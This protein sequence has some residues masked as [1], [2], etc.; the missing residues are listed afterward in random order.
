MPKI[1]EGMGSYTI[2]KPRAELQR[3]KLEAVRRGIT[4]AEFFDR[5]IEREL[6][7]GRTERLT[8][9]PARRRSSTEGRSDDKAP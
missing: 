4:M 6:R 1:P 3:I 7:E 8:A 2:I 5:A 9:R